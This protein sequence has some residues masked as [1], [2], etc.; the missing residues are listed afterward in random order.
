MLA[1]KHLGQ[2]D[3]RDVHPCLDRAVD[4]GV[5]GLN[6]MRALVAASRLGRC[7]TGG[8]IGAYP[9]YCGRDLDTADQPG[10]L[11]RRDMRLVAV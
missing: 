6:A 4:D 9:T 11:I 7:R 1:V 10:V 8:S 2:L 3:Q 5:K